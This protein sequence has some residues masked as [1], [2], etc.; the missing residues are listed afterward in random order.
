MHRKLS[1]REA[2]KE[3]YTELIYDPLPGFRQN[4]GMQNNKLGKHKA[5]AT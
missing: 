2:A 4:V 3:E 1:I 5:R